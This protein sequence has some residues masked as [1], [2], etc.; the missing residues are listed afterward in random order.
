MKNNIRENSEIKNLVKK[1]L[2]LTLQRLIKSKC[3]S[4]GVLVVSENGVIRKIKATNLTF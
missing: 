1:G 3:Q 4:N 2:D